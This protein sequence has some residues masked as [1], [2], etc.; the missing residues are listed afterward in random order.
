M[1]KINIHNEQSY[2]VAIQQLSG[3]DPTK[4]WTFELKRKVKGRTNAQNNLF[5]QWMSIAGKETG[6][7]KD[8]FSLLMKEKFLIPET[9]E[10]YGMKAERYKSTADMGTKELADFMKLI[11]MFCARDLGIVL[12]HPSDLHHEVR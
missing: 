1:T 5:W 2:A 12:P 10:K 9:V 7:F 4:G 8:E 3:I 11:D 6:Y